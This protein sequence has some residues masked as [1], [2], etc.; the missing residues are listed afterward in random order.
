MSGNVLGAED[1]TLNTIAKHP[2]NLNHGRKDI[3]LKIHSFQIISY[4]IIL[5]GTKCCG[6]NKLGIGDRGCQKDTRSN[7]VSEKAS[8]EVTI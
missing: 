2:W 5:E 1:T 4:Y 6:G 8:G 3:C 7:K